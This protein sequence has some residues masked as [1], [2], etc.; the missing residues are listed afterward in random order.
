MYSREWCTCNIFSFPPLCPSVT[1]FPVIGRMD[2]FLLAAGRIVYT[3]LARISGKMYRIASHVMNESLVSPQTAADQ[4]EPYVEYFFLPIA[5]D[6]PWSPL[7][8]HWLVVEGILAH[9]ALAP[10]TDLQAIRWSDRHPRRH[11][12]PA[13]DQCT[14]TELPPEYILVSTSDCSEHIQD[15]QGIFVSDDFSVC[16]G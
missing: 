11:N 2:A 14:S 6:P 7:P 13:S 12:H 1:E 10:A 3:S 8:P 16:C 15:R 4:L 9:Q 5:L